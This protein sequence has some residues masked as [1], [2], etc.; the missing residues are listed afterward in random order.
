[1]KKKKNGDAT[2]VV[3]EKEDKSTGKC[4]N[5]CGEQA[6]PGSNLCSSCHNLY[7]NVGNGRP[8]YKDTG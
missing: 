3:E 6:M 4:D 1:M 7:E 2:T 8:L 5:R